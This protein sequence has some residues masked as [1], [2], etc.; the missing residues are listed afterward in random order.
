MSQ[1]NP[2]EVAAMEKS[3][4]TLKDGDDKIW[5]GQLMVEV[6]TGFLD[7]TMLMPTRTQVYIEK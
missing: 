4:V 3:T 5:V 1:D 6:A 7:E 2:K